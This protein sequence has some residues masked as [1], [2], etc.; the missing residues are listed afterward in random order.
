MIMRLGHSPYLRRRLFS[1]F[2]GAFA[3]P[4]TFCEHDEDPDIVREAALRLG[5]IGIVS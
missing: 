3:L 5:I 2:S 4:Q 1:N